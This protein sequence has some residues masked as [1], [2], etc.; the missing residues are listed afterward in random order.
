M[1]C[2]LSVETDYQALDLKGFGGSLLKSIFPTLRFVNGIY[3]DCL[4]G[5]NNFFFVGLE[6]M[7]TLLL[8]MKSINSSS[9][10][11]IISSIYNSSSSE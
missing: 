6:V 3:F 1:E 7:L 2:A 10:I 11:E 5:S 8:L 4:A 9:G